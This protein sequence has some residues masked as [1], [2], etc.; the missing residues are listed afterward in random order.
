MKIAIVGE[1]EEALKALSP[2][3]RIRLVQ[4]DVVDAVQETDVVLL[5]EPDHAQLLATIGQIKE[6][7]ELRDKEHTLAYQIIV[8]SVVR[9]GTMEELN[10]LLESK[11]EFRLFY[12]PIVGGLQ[13]SPPCL[14]IGTDGDDNFSIIWSIWR[15]VFEASP[16]LVVMTWEEAEA[17]IILHQLLTKTTSSFVR[18]MCERTGV[19]LARVI[20][21][22]NVLGVKL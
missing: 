4:G 19:D 2:F 14:L 17:T 11:N 20:P 13:C 5:F 21:I 12:N 3:H 10:S 16:P 22:L 15:G 7:I 8:C 1:A 6:G 18:E 9:S